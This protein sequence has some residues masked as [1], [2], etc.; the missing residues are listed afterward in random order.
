M[1]KGIFQLLNVRERAWAKTYR[2]LGYV[3]P[4]TSP[5][6]VVQA[7]ATQQTARKNV[8]LTSELSDFSSDSEDETPPAQTEKVEE[9][10]DIDDTVEPIG[11]TV[12]AA[13]IYLSCLLPFGNPYLGKSLDIVGAS[14]WKE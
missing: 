10:S 5:A 1:V 11:R 3:A 6:P 8:I 2:R 4:V 12:M 13:V 9:A 7:P 14:W